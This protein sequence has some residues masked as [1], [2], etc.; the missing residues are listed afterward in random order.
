MLTT[1]AMEGASKNMTTE[2]ELFVLADVQLVN[3][4]ARII[5]FVICGGQPSQTVAR[6]AR[7]S[8]H[9]RENRPDTERSGAER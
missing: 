2:I 8:I 9:C 4:T 7:E 5:S 1:V 3:S 6:L